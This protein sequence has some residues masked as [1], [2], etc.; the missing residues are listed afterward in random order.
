MKHIKSAESTW[1]ADIPA[2]L[3]L[4]TKKARMGKSIVVYAY[5]SLVVVAV[6]LCLSLQRT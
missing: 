1:N 4:N 5:R 2:E 3:E 6:V